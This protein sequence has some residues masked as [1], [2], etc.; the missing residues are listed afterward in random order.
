MTAVIRKAVA[1]LL[2]AQ[3]TMT[4]AT[5]LDGMPWA[6]TVFYASDEAFNLY[7]VSDPRT[8][9]ARHILAN[10]QVALSISAAARGWEEVSGLQVAGRALQL[11]EPARKQALALYLE[12]FPAVQ[13]LAENPQTADEALIAGRLAHTPFWRVT[14]KTIRLLDGSRGFGWSIELSP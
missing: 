11:D 14:P 5:S 10:P 3:R 4:L 7:F 9:H 12:K 13:A 1:G 6:A 8:R 2:A